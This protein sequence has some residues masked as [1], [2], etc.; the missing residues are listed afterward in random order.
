MENTLERFRRELLTRS[1]EDY[2]NDGHAMTSLTDGLTRL[3]ET[4]VQL[5][6]ADARE[7]IAR[8]GQ[9]GVRRLEA[10]G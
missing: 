5:A 9:L 10:V 4:A 3:R 7:V 2:R 8:F 6:Q 1:A